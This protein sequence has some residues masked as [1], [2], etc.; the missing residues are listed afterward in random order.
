[1]SGLLIECASPPSCATA[2]VQQHHMY[3]PIARQYVAHAHVRQR[4]LTCPPPCTPAPS[5]TRLPAEVRAALKDASLVA[6]LLKVV[7]KKLKKGGVGPAKL[8][9]LSAKALCL[10]AGLLDDLA[11]GRIRKKVRGPGGM[12][13]G[14]PPTTWAG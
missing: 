14:A 7:V 11:L 8:R 4:S 3:Q 13:C 12:G 10:E 1:M 2:N 5:V 9:K 6:S